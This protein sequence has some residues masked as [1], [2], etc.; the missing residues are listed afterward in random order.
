MDDALE[1]H[2]RAAQTDG[3]VRLLPNLAQNPRLNTFAHLKASTRTDPFPLPEASSLWDVLDQEDLLRGVE[4][5][6]ADGDDDGIMG[7]SQRPLS[8]LS[9]IRGERVR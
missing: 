3:E 9:L 7:E 1:G 4:D 8:P 6:G 2:Q 5:D